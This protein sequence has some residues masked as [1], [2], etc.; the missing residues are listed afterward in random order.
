MARDGAEDLFRPSRRRRRKPKGVTRGEGG[1]LGSMG[2]VSNAEAPD[3]M[4]LGET[5][6]K[7]GTRFLGKEKM[8]E[9]FTEKIM[10]LFGSS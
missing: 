5:A 2:S 10:K 1:S 6:A 3:A 9:M 7:L 4:A 8:N